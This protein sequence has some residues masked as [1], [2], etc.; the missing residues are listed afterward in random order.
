M[1]IF[2]DRDCGDT[3]PTCP[4]EFD[5]ERVRQLRYRFTIG[6]YTR[7]SWR[8]RTSCYIEEVVRVVEESITPVS[9][10]EEVGVLQTDEFLEELYLIPH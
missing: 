8:E 3:L 5:I 4:Q 7:R 6:K 10:R 2:S 1:S 9:D